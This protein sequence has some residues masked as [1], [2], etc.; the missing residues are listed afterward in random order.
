MTH[1]RPPSILVLAVLSL[2]GGVLGS[3][4]NILVV[5]QP[6]AQPVIDRAV[7]AADNKPPD[8]SQV[9][10]GISLGE[11]QPEV[12]TWALAVLDLG[13][14]LLIVVLGIG[15]LRMRPWA[16]RL[17][18]WC[19]ALV[20]LSSLAAVA[21]DIWQQAT[22]PAEEADT[23]AGPVWQAMEM[24]HNAPA[25][26]ITVTVIVAAI[27]VAYGMALFLVLRK[28]ACAE[29]FANAAGRTNTAAGP[30]HPQVNSK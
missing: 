8:P 4:C 28:P 3:C 10:N 11:T 27:W 14:C 15:L 22:K 21:I 23:Q 18:L 2:I 17:G 12:A 19:A 25:L 6:L 29:A 1:Q 30:S 5:G 24:I 20:I 7:A 13:L 26:S 16:R 9:K